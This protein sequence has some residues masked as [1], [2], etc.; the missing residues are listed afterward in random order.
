MSRV[1][2]AVRATTGV[3]GELL[4]TAGA[5]LLLFLVWQLWWTDVQADAAQR[6]VTDQLQQDWDTG[7]DEAPPTAAADAPPPPEP[8]PAEGDAFAV[9]H[10]PRFGAGWQPRPV[11]EGTSLEL[12]EDG[13]GHYPGT[14]LPGAVGNLAVAGHRVTYGKPFNQVEQLRTGDAVLVETAQ[15]WYTYRVT[16]TQI[17]RPDQ[18]EVIAAVPGDETAV[19]TER[20]LTLTTCHPMFSARERFVVHAV[21]EEWQPRSDGAPTALG[22]APGGG[23]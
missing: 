22:E 5:L 9:V 14:A 18:V 1:G 11:Y 17:V 21:L 12:L 3:V 19:P 7:G 15:A 20:V 6:E 13:V 2:R 10:V 16:S 8:E 4:I 23:A